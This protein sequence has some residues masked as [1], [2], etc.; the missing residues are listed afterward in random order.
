MTPDIRKGTLT[1]RC[2]STAVV[3]S[4]STCLFCQLT[5]EIS[6]EQFRDLPNHAN[7]KAFYTFMQGLAIF[8]DLFHFVN[9]KKNDTYCQTMTNPSRFPSLTGDQRL[10][11]L[12]TLHT[13][14]CTSLHMSIC[15]F[16]LCGRWKN[17]EACEQLFR[18]FG[19][20]VFIINSQAIN[21]ATLTV[22]V[23]FWERAE[24]QIVQSCESF[25]LMPTSRLAEVR[26]SYG[27]APEPDSIQARRELWGLLLKGEREWS[28]EKL[29]A[30]RK[31]A[32]ET[33]RG[34][35]G[36]KPKV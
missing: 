26:A 36:K 27:L 18:W 17:T 9:H 16:D 22:A 13:A 3:P 31:V 25:N 7:T 28:P 10:C 32:G 35:Q 23:L 34:R 4:M 1:Q 14:H 2:A 6:M 33:S 29:A 12:S 21:K 30:H 19:R 24:R 5:I 15:V 20:I 8:V 11:E